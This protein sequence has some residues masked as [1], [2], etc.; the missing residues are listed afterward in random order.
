[1]DHIIK[2]VADITE[3]LISVADE[4][5]SLKDVTRIWGNIPVDDEE[6]MTYL[7][8]ANQCILEISNLV[9]QR[10]PNLSKTE[11][12]AKKYRLMAKLLELKA[13]QLDKY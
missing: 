13:D 10:Y 2:R 11:R 6:G 8:A 1:M 3:E 12:L 7:E 9:N 4:G 5:Y